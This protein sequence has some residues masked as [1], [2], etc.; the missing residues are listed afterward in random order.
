VIIA[1]SQEYE[2]SNA[3]AGRLL[4]YQP[5]SDIEAMIDKELA[6]RG[7]DARTEIIS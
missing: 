2:I 6:G 7:T 3:K 5:T 1:V 4:G